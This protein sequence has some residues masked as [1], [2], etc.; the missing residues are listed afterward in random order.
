MWFNWCYRFNWFNRIHSRRTYLSQLWPLSYPPEFIRSVPFLLG[1][2]RSSRKN[3]GRIDTSS[4]CAIYATPSIYPPSSFLLLRP[5]RPS[6]KW[7]ASRQYIAI[8]TLPTVRKKHI[9][10]GKSP[11][12]FKKRKPNQANAQKENRL[13]SACF[14]G[15][16]LSR[17]SSHLIELFDEIGDLID[18][19]YLI[20]MIN[21]I[22]S[23]ILIAFIWMMSLSPLLKFI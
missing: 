10:A 3:W 18:L 2:P 20:D 16:F 12:K 1:S 23:V 7:R 13:K 6:E 15:A 8:A 5:P 11:R 22:D 9:W 17:D 21:S 14:S 19:I 4:R